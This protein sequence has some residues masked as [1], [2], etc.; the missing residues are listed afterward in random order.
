MYGLKVNDANIR[1]ERLRRMMQPERGGYAL[2]TVA[3]AGARVT[4][5]V[6]THWLG[7]EQE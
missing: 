2:S 4:A 7:K 1:A 5:L 3:D 6:A